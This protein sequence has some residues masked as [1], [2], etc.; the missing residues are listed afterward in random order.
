MPGYPRNA[1][2][3]NPKTMPKAIPTQVKRKRQTV[4]VRFSAAAKENNLESPTTA[5]WLGGW[6]LHPWSGVPRTP[7]NSHRRLGSDPGSACDF[8]PARAPT[9]PPKDDMPRGHDVEMGI[10]PQTVSRAQACLSCGTDNGYLTALPSLGCLPDGN[11]SNI[12]LN[13]PL[14]STSNWQKGSMRG[15]AVFWD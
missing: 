7:T 13:R 6:T 9:P 3:A 2:N 14:P 8:P 4:W 15:K 10:V 5:A 1:Q 11:F 12:D